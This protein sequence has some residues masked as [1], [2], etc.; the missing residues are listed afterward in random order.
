MA[1]NPLTWPNR[2]L[3]SEH[4]TRRQQAEP[5]VCPLLLDHGLAVMS[6]ADLTKTVPL[7]LLCYCSAFAQVSSTA[8]THWKTGSPVGLGASGFELDPE[9]RDKVRR[10]ILDTNIIHA[11]SESV[12]LTEDDK[13][14]FVVAPG[15]ANKEE[16]W[17]YSL[18]DKWSGSCNRFG[19]QLNHYVLARMDGHTRECLLLG[20]T[21][22]LADSNIKDAYLWILA[23]NN[24]VLPVTWFKKADSGTTTNKAGQV[25]RNWVSYTLVDGEI[26]WRYTLSFMT[27]GSLDGIQT[28]KFDAKELDPKFQSIMKEVDSEVA[29]E[30]KQR[31]LS[32]KLGAVQSYWLLKKEKLKAKGIDWRSPA[33]LNLGVIYE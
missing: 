33:E 3:K 7:L 19:E 26:G 14:L 1:Q 9:L 2:A 23:T 16:V 29:A 4:E 11:I 20:I 13:K 31:G 8:P 21:N 24:P 25:M 27:N 22:R 30:L 17:L 10:E 32:G 5:G 28:F 18:T 12:Q 6:A 15:G